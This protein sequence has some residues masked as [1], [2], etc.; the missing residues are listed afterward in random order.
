[1]ASLSSIS[2]RRPFWRSD[3]IVTFIVMLYNHV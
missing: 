2:S 3:S 1:M